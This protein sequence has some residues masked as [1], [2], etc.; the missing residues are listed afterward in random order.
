MQREDKYLQIEKEQ[1]DAFEKA[2]KK[3]AED[4]PEEDEDPLKFDE[5]EETVIVEEIPIS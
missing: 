3:L 1:E 4:H 5:K 2:L